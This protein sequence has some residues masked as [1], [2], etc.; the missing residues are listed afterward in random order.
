MFQS[1]WEASQLAQHKD[2]GGEMQNMHKQTCKSAYNSKPFFCVVFDL[3]AFS[4]QEKLNN[5]K[6]I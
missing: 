1:G 6:E 3:S 4:R 2:I 5:P